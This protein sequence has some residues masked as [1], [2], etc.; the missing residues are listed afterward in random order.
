[1][2][3]TAVRTD[4]RARDNRC[5]VMSR[6]SGNLSAIL[7]V[8]SVLTYA[9]LWLAFASNWGWI[10]ALDNGTVRVFHEFGVTRPGWITFW[11]TVSTAFGP[12][13]MRLIALVGI[14]VAAVR[15]QF[16]IAGFLVITV[17]LMGPLTA[18]AKA[19]SN[20]PRPETALALETSTAFP[21]GHALGATVG[22]LSFLTV[23]WPEI[24][25]RARVPAIAAGTLVVL[26]VSLAR[27][28]LNVHH[29]TDIV[30]G[31][32]LGYL[33]YRSCL[34]AIPPR[35]SGPRQPGHAAPQRVSPRS[36]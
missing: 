16:H 21:S 10:T 30:A 26:S 20:R 36:G 22:V 2:M 28:A 32:A 7:V 9:A 13:A 14:V 3:L 29:P 1:M 12:S 27:V 15:R 23:L 5:P 4:T 33:W 8:V 25:R 31:W 24:P 19:I 35:Q 18:V 6:K 34:I 17:M 11:V